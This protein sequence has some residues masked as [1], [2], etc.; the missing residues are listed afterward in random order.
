[1]TDVIIIAAITCVLLMVVAFL[2]PSV[3]IKSVNV[4][5]FWIVPFLGAA[6]MI[7]TGNVS[8]NDIIASFTAD[9]AVNPLKILILFISMTL[10]SVY[11]DCVGFFRFLASAVLEK[12][13][14]SQLTLFFYLYVTVSILTIFTSNDIIVLT[15]TPFICY[16]A[17]NA[18]IDP[19]PYLITEFI[20]ANTWSMILII[21]NPTNIYLATNAGASFAS[22]TLKMALPT[23]SAG[24]VSLVVL[25]L[26]FRT[27]L[28]KPIKSS[29]LKEKIKNKGAVTIGLVH[30]AGSLVFMV[31]S[32]YIDLPMWII[33]LGFC[34]SLFV[35]SS[36]YFII[37]KKGFRTLSDTVRRTPVETIPFVLSMFVIVLALQNSGI[38]ETI[39][40]NL[41]NGNAVLTFGA[42]S[43]FAANLINNIPMSV[44]YSSITS[45]ADATTY[46]QALY[47]SVIGSNLGAFFT[48]LGALAG[49][50]WTN[51]LKGSNVRMNFARFTKY[52][53]AVALPTLAASLFTLAII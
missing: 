3:T 27:R 20:A 35:T 34:V 47:A 32:S 36:I 7:L 11:L 1:M 29:G 17:K 23:F 14:K 38:T 48:P 25:F 13:G 5:V 16:F 43:F 39:A 4:P 52:G 50:M 22:Y 18:E 12:A 33:S 8:V 26:I 31:I 15:F 42:T 51:M 41:A 28:S 6:A 46:S 24:V 37:S 19:I 40:K 9:S 2:K 53:T 49:I 44:L 21:G 30:L 10:I 45:F